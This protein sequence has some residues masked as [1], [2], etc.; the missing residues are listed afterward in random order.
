M[1]GSTRDEQR[2]TEILKEAFT[3]SLSPMWQDSSTSAQCKEIEEFSGA[4]E[5]EKGGSGVD[6]RLLGQQR[7]AEL[8]GSRA[9]E[10]YTASQILKIRQAS[11]DVYLA[12]VRISLVSSFVASLLLGKFALIDVADG[13]GMNLLDVDTK[14]W[15]PILMTF[16][17]RGGRGGSNGPETTASV[18]MTSEDSGKSPYSLTEKLGPVDASGRAVQGYLCNW[19]QERYGF[20]SSKCTTQS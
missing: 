7:L 2:L 4:L 9:Y 1:H 8:T 5:I 15:D 3:V 17:A 20:N 10:R 16:I 19:F 12:T 11:P 6:V 14:T 13:S 18:T